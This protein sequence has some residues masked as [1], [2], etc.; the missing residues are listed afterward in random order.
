MDGFARGVFAG[1]AAA[2]CDD[3]GAGSGTHLDAEESGVAVDGGVE[4]VEDVGLHAQED[5]LGFGVAEAGVELEDHGAARGHHDA[6]EEDA[7]EGR[8]FGFHAGHDLL[9]Y[10]GGEPLA[11]G[12]GEEAVGR[13][14]SHAAGV[15]AGVAFADTLVILRGGDGC[16][17]GA[18]AE[19]EEGE[20]FAGEELLEDDLGLLVPRRVPENIS[21][22]AVSAWRR[23][24]QM[25]TPLP[26]ARPSALTTTGR[27]KVRSCSRT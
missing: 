20:L 2:G 23:V 15:G 24:S 18:V 17:V 21:A 4:E 6:A 25:T 13:V 19:S 5:G 3:A 9:G 27:A 22:A 12:C 1:V 8:A 26:A 16:G 14:G 7:F 10:V 11:H